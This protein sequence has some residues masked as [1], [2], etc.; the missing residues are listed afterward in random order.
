MLQKYQE[1]CTGDMTTFEIMRTFANLVGSPQ[2]LEEIEE[3]GDR[4]MG[5]GDGSGPDEGK[6]DI[7]CGEERSA[8]G[9][10]QGHGNNTANGN[11]VAG[12]A[13]EGRQIRSKSKQNDAGRERAVKGKIDSGDTTTLRSPSVV[14]NSVEDQ[15]GHD[16]A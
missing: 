10:N 13:P 2:R 3:E 12:Q 1:I 4:P 11:G 16:D 15:V 8:H 9:T 5:D 6:N 14:E 7:R